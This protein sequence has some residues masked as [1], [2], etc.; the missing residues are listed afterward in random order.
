ML[1][2]VY[3][4]AY[5]SLFCFKRE[6]AYEVRIS[7]WSSD[8]CSSDLLRQIALA[9]QPALGLV[10]GD[11][12]AADVAAVE[13]VAGRLQTGL[14]AAA[15]GSAL[16]VRHVLQRP[17]EILLAEQLAGPR[18]RAAGQIDPGIF[19]PLAVFLGLLGDHRRGQAMDREAVAGPPDRAGRDV[20]ERHGAVGA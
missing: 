4:I 15:G 8:V 13:G 17:A 10:E 19:V 18:R 3:V 11:D 14:A 5:S 2:F 6:T 1:L 9:Q 16:L 12:P 20:A 7:D